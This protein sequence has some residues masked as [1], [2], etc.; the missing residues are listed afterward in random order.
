MRSGF[1]GSD[2]AFTPHPTVE[3]QCLM[4]LLSGRPNALDIRF[5]LYYS[6]EFAQIINNKLYFLISPG[7]VAYLFSN[8]T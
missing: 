4:R 2:K 6:S 7:K 1:C 8:K 3:H 5:T